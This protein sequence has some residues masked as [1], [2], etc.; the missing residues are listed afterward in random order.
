MSDKVVVVTGASGGVGRAVVRQLG[1]QGAIV[2]LIARGEAGLAGAAVEVGVGGGSAKVFSADVANYDEV[3]R[4]AQRIEAELGPI[5]VWINVAFTTVFAPFMEITPEEFER[6]T[7]VTYL[8]YVWGTRA[9]LEVMKPRDKGVIVQAGSALAYRAIPLQSAYCGAKHAIKG[10]TESVRTELFAED[11]GVKITMVQLP[12]LNTPQ[13]DWGLTRVRRHP[14]P[15]PPIYQPEVAARAVLFAAEHP[16]RREYWV[17]ATTAATIMAEKFVPGL[18]D[19]YLGRT[20]VK[21]QQIEGKAPTGVSNL[22]EPADDERDYGAHG[23][24]DDRSHQRSVQVWMSQHR[25]LVTAG[26]AGLAAAA[27]YALRRRH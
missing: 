15:V 23:S 25:R 21:S 14:Q 17:G 11:S 2:A 26:A 4:A 22:W 18:L 3:R 5:D 10:F 24:F 1:D 20:G 9:A 27:A 6:T 8:G 12:A 16:E 7:Q 13:F 19:R